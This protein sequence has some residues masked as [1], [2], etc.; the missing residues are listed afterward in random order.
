LNAILF[1]GFQKA[2][3]TIGDQEKKI[4]ALDATVAK[5]Q[6][7]LESLSARFG[8]RVCFQPKR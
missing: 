2:H 8:T 3:H 5:L 4:E 7:T 6:A 1:N